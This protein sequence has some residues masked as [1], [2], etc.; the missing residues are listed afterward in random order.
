[1]A[2]KRRQKRGKGLLLIMLLLLGWSVSELAP[3]LYSKADPLHLLFDTSRFHAEMVTHHL[4]A[5]AQSDRT[6]DLDALLQSLYA[7]RYVHNH[8]SEATGGDI[9][10]L[11][12]HSALIDLIFRWQL[13]GDRGLTEGE[14]ELFKT[15]HGSYLQLFDSYQYMMSGT[16]VDGSRTALISELDINMVEV[17]E[18]WER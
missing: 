6:G 3:H 9:P 17:I 2:L 11:Y 12:S 16:S 4:N 5:A 10:A 14:K 13:G 1:V 18:A 8:L 7:F 15:I